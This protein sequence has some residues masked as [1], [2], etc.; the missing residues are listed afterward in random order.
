MLMTP[1]ITIANVVYD[2]VRWLTWMSINYFVY[3][4]V[5]YYVWNPIHIACDNIYSFLWNSC[6]SQP[7]VYKLAK[8]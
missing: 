7:H 6:S 4:I 1:S 3:Y 8:V 2:R 5:F